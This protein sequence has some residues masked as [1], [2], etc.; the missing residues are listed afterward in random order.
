MLAHGG[1][2]Y[3][4]G[5]KEVFLGLIVEA[6]VGIKHHPVGV[7]VGGGLA[8]RR[9]VRADHDGGLE[10]SGLSRLCMRQASGLS[11]LCMRQASGL[12]RL[13]MTQAIA[14]GNL[15]RLSIRV[16]GGWLD[17]GGGGDNGCP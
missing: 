8:G 6:S 1:L 13:C 9:N 12:S 4:V 14:A 15:C 7:A 3:G 11:R 16:L 17:R 2:G 5:T 10:A